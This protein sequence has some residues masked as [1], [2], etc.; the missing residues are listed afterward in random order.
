MPKFDSSAMI[1]W[2]DIV[3]DLKDEE[4]INVIAY[5]SQRAYHLLSN[6]V[7]NISRNRE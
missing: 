4:D 1:R 3:S 2:F 6:E 7:S 5:S